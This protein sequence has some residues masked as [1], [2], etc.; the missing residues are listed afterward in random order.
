MKITKLKLFRNALK[1]IL[2]GTGIVL[3][4]HEYFQFIRT[5]KNVIVNSDGRFWTFWKSTFWKFQKGL[6]EGKGEQDTSWGGSP[7]GVAGQEGGGAPWS[8][9]WH[10]HM[11]YSFGKGIFHGHFW[12]FE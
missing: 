1:I 2:V 4:P 5:L 8:S 12:Y 9:T 10:S 6:L 7:H 11:A 3:S